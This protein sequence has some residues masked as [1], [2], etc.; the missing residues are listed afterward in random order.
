MAGVWVEER[1]EALWFV[2][3]PDQ[4]RTAAVSRTGQPTSQIFVFCAAISEPIVTRC[5]L[6]PWV[7]WL[8]RGQDGR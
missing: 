8:W 5:G 7:S 2:R 6:P 1:S 4:R 3:V